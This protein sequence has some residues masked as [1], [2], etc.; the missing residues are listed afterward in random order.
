MNS[1]RLYDFAGDIHLVNPKYEEL[2]GLRCYP[3]V[4]ALPEDPEIGVLMTGA[5]RVAPLA[6]EL[7]ARGCKR[8][9]IVS[10]GFAEAGTEEGRANDQALRDTF[11]GS[12][13]LVVGP[14]CVGFASFHESLCAITQPVPAG[15][16]PGNVSV[17]SQSG[18]LT[19]A[20]MG[21]IV[22]DGLGLDVCYSIG[23]GSVFGVA[24]AIR[25]AVERESTK[26]VAAVVE[27][28]DNPDELERAAELARASGKVIVCLQLGQS[29]S[30]RGIAQSHTGVIAGEQRLVA[31]WMQRLGIVLA[32]TAEEMGRVASLV[33]K[34][35]MPDAD[36]GTFIATVSG[37]GAGLAAD[38]AARHN[39]R[40]AQL[41]PATTERLRE[42]ATATPS[43]PRSRATP[44]SSC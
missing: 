14:N 4:A 32:D 29:E 41:R 33:L 11:A 6:G 26:V 2:F 23:N 39:V 12:D 8:F 37:G 20:A 38:L 28:V 44:A 25:S 34:F 10:N 16:T 42:L 21:A 1:L 31:A 30:G 3:S 36:R 19:G 9:V 13:A 35:G 24:S 5:G 43:T 15:I 18:G 40:L 7:L 27:S 17:V 22:G